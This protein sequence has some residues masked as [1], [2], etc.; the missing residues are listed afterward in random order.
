MT[1][2]AQVNESKKQFLEEK[3][4]D[5]NER[6]RQFELRMKEQ[7]DQFKKDKK[8]AEEKNQKKIEELQR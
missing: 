8:I 3:E 2:Q 4:K 7:T 6:Q 1:D 5:L